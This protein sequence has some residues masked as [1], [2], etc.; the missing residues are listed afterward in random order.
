MGYE[1]V[2]ADWLQPKRPEKKALEL[3]G[4]TVAT[5]GRL[6]MMAS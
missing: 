1:K 5:I 3:E 4:T 6:E 2:M